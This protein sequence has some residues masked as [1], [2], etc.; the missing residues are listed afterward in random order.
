MSRK[1]LFFQ[2][3]RRDGFAGF[4][5]NHLEKVVFARHHGL[6]TIKNELVRLGARASLMSGSGSTLV[7]IFLDKAR[8]EQAV[9][10]FFQKARVMGQ[11][12]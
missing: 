4:C 6:E 5:V 3:L 7:G 12:L 10:T 9:K 11:E 8:A 2:R 1:R